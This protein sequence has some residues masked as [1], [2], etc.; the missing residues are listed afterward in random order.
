MVSCSDFEYLKYVI[1]YTEPKAAPIKENLEKC[2]RLY[3]IYS[4][5]VKTYYEISRGDYITKLVE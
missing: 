5:I 4:D 2:S 1:A 3:N